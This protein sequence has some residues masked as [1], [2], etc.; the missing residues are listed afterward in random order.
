MKALPSCARIAGP[1][2][3]REHSDLRVFLEI[4]RRQLRN[5]IETGERAVLA[6]A[7]DLLEI[8][9]ELASL[10]GEVTARPA[11]AL[12]RIEQ[13][14]AAALGRIQFQDTVKQQTEIIIQAL[15]QLDGFA[16]RLGSPEQLPDTSPAHHSR[17]VSELLHE[18]YASYISEQQRSIHEASLIH[19]APFAEPRPELP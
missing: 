3:A 16:A 1:D 10:E 4:L 5:S 17:S 13:R 18:L 11:A 9:R 6:L 7:G 2:L 15:R 8:D 19:A 12:A 14:L